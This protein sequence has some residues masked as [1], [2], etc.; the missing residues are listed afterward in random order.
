MNESTPDKNKGLEATMH[1]D[2]DEELAN[3]D[4]SKENGTKRLEDGAKI[5]ATMD[6]DWGAVSE[7]IGSK[8]DEESADL[9]KAR[10]AL[11]IQ[12]TTDSPSIVTLRKEQE[13]ATK[14]ILTESE[15][16]IIVSAEQVKIAVSETNPALET[17]ENPVEK[18]IKDFGLYSEEA[19]AFGKFVGQNKPN[20]DDHEFISKKDDLLARAKELYQSDWSPLYDNA[21][22]TFKNGLGL[23]FNKLR[24]V[25]EDGLDYGS[26]VLGGVKYELKSPLDFSKTIQNIGHAFDSVKSMFEYRSRLQKK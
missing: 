16:P 19:K 23:H 8:I 10:E 2:W 9:K 5:E 3:I 14:Q 1:V 21:D 15:K 18:L 17:V 25:I 13:K 7:E 4:N 20:L 24:T 26:Y 6:V 22:S 12:D 11:G